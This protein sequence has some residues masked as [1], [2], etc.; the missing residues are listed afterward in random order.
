MESFTPIAS[1][2]GGI[3]IG[4]SSALLL[5]FNGRIAGISGITGAL[6]EPS[7]ASGERAWRIAFVLG[8]VV[9][10]FVAAYLS[11]TSFESTI[12]RSTIAI[13]LAGL[14]VGFGTRT[15]SGCTSGHGVCGLGRLSGRSLAAVLTFIT[16]GAIT[17]FVVRT[18]FGGSV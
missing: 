6:I 3:L 12:N 14:A 18:V 8:L 11:P 16:T 1:L 5:M 10:G 7:T 13:A 4:I 9:T 15:G 17:V 2:I